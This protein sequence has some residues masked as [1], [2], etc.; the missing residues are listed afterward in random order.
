MVGGFNEHLGT[1]PEGMVKIAGTLGLIDLMASR[2]SSSPPAT[3]ARGSK[4][5]DYAL[6]NPLASDALI[7]AG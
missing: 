6:A 3:Y 4:R 5:L 2:H 7:S 1:D